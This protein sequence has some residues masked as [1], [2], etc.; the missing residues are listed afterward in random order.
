M[1]IKQLDYFICDV[2][3]LYVEFLTM[4][5]QFLKHFKWKANNFTFTQEKSNYFHRILQ[6]KI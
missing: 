1:Q 3:T 6:S 5:N 2:K 4:L